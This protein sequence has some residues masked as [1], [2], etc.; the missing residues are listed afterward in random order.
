MQKKSTFYVMA[1]ITS[2]IMI[3]L[4]DKDISPLL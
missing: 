3:I 2:I 1:I 4:N